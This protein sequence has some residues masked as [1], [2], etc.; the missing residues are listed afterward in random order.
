MNAL[1]S[2]RGVNRLLCLGAHCDD[3]EIG[4]GGTIL[5]LLKE[6]PSIHV[7]WVVFSG[8]EQRH[9]E[10][11]AC[12]Q[13]FLG[14]HGHHHITFHLFRDG[15][16]PFQG[17]AIKQAFEALKQLDAPDLILTH[18][19]DDAHQDHRMVNQLTC[20]TFRN[21]LI[22]EYEIIKYDGDLGRP[23]VYITL[24]EQLIGRKVEL[25][26]N[27]YASQSSKHW[28]SAETFTGLARV[29]GVQAATTWAEA[30]YCRKWAI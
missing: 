25:L 24:D 15:F 11:R 20:N 8:P 5:R 23:N 6:N 17:E 14:T 3:I 13:A 7:D 1:A 28:Y 16:F 26:M 30:F 21:H 4:A 29:R 2:L 18:F 10:A 27:H 12:A 9:T 22:W 19:R